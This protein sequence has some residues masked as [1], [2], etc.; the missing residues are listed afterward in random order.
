V[1]NFLLIYTGYGIFVAPITLTLLAVDCYQRATASPKEAWLPLAAWI[2]SAGSLALFF[3]GYVF[4]SAAA[5]FQFPYPSPSAYPV[6]MGFMFAKFLGLKHG[7]VFPAAIGIF[8]VLLSVGVCGR[9]FWSVWKCGIKEQR[10]FVGFTLAAY[11]LLYASAAAVGRVCL[12]MQAAGAARNLTLLI[13]GFLALYFQI[14]MDRDSR[15]RNVLGL[16]FVL[17]LIPGCVQRNH[18]E[19]EGFSAMK[20]AWKDCYRRTENIKYCDQVSHLQLFPWPEGIHMREKLEYLKQNRLNLY[21]NS[22]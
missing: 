10:S 19:I 11:T 9:Q 8:F 16:V 18:K 5:C 3:L 2:A 1:L 7:T 6:F 20:R 21:A 12:G 22:D 17:I 13:P 4:R 14:L 15:R